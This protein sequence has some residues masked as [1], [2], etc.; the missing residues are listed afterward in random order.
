MG[1]WGARGPDTLWALGAWGA[2][3]PTPA[4]DL[5]RGGKA[6]GGFWVGA[7]CQRGARRKPPHPSLEANFQL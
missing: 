5:G 7:K 1:G 2:R 3:R 4:L 6:R